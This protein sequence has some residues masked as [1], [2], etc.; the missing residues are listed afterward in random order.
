M[1]ALLEF[2]DNHKK[3]YLYGAGANGVLLADDLLDKNVKISGIVVTHRSAGQTRLLGLPIWEVKELAVLDNS[4]C[5][6]I[7]A[8]GSNFH[9]EVSKTLEE[10]GFGYFFR[11]PDIFFH[12]LR[13][14][15]RKI[16]V[17]EVLSRWPIQRIN[18]LSPINWRRILLIRLDGIGDMVLFTP[19]LRVLRKAHPESEITLIVQPMVYN[20]VE[21]CPHI[22][23]LLAYDWRKTITWPFRAR[24][25]HVREYVYEHSLTRQYDVVMNP[26]W[27]E[28]YYDAGALAYFTEAPFRVAW[29]ENVS[30]IKSI[31][32]RGFD[33]FY[34]TTMLDKR[35]CHEVEHN[36]QFLALLGIGVNNVYE[37]IG[38]A[39]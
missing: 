23:H 10:S 22:D 14:N 31:A 35:I 1:D 25:R 12:E 17:P 39:Q 26:R 7:F 34:T 8:L 28:D 4:D 19:F 29:S 33:N 21:A 2:I 16:S 13:E 24:C 38:G 11:L 9:C 6:F 27:G 32:N 5:G 18:Y 3:V 30:P 36:M 15:I 37:S 20:L